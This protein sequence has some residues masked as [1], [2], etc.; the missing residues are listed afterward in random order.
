MFGYVVIEKPE[1]KVKEFEIYNAVYCSLCRK[2]GK[3]YGPLSKFCLN[4]D[5]TFVALLEAALIEKCSEFEQKRCRVN[6]LKKCTYCKNDDEF[7]GLAAAAGVALFDLK[8]RDNIEDGGFFSKI[9]FGF[10]RLFT[11]RWSKKA[12]RFYPLL[13]EIVLEYRM[14][15]S[16]AEKDKECSLDKA[17]EP[18]AKA[19]SRIFSLISVEEKYKFVLERMGYCLGKWI[20][21]L[22]AA[23][24]IEKD[25]K[26]GNFNPLV[27]RIGNDYSKEDLKET[28]EPILNNCIVECRNYCELLDIKKHKNIIDNILYLGLENKQKKILNKEKAK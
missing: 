9:A 18:S 11:K 10:L 28:L 16:F 26:T 14:F 8:V 5:F 12:Y 22:D 27:A 1:L 13:R 6:P 4:Y 20:Y 19:L 15:Q 2:M 25:I 7:L 24:D 21:L 3:T 17:A 23:D